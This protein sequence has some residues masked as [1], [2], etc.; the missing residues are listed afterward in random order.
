MNKTKMLE[1]L[2]DF[3]A[4]KKPAEALWQQDAQ[5][6]GAA[7]MIGAGFSRGASKHADGTRK[8]PLWKGLRRSELHGLDRSVEER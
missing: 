6:Q 2:P 8:L 3:P 4:L 5:P 1:T 7:I